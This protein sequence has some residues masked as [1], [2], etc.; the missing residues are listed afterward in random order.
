MNAHRRFAATSVLGAAL[1]ALAGC[2]H[3]PAHDSARVGPFHAA[4]NHGAQTQLPANLRRVVLL[5]VAGGSVADAESSA[6]LSAVFAAELQKCNRF[7]VVTLT[8]EDVQRRF[9]QPEVL[10]T[11]ALPHDFMVKLR[12]DLAVDGVMFVDLTAYK[13]YRPLV[14]GVRA[15]LAMAGEDV[16]LVWAFD[17]IF[18]TADPAVA[19]SARNHF[20][21][22]DRGGVPAD[23]SPGVLHSPSKFAEYVAAQAF[24][25]LPPVYT[26]PPVKAVTKRRGEA[27]AV[28]NTR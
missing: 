25:T 22:S 14:I 19:N 17:N 7:E 1:I 24:S 18:S 13:P 12:R 21:D 23:L 8:R 11:A 28:A 2:M 9:R 16:Q 5:P 3:P 26:P 20:I 15:K 10:S 4:V 27:V 6:T